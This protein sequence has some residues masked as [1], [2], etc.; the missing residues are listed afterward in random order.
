MRSAI[1]SL[2]AHI[3]APEEASSL[4][5]H[6]QVLLDVINTYG[7]QCM[8]H[9][10]I[11]DTIKSHS[12]EVYHLYHLLWWHRMNLKDCRIFQHKLIKLS[13]ITTITTTTNDVWLDVI[14]NTDM[15]IVLGDPFLQVVWWDRIYRRS[16]QGDLAVLSIV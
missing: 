10:D 9:I 11:V 12:P 13:G 7:I 4:L 5:S 1:R 16:L 2:L 14:D 15:R 3:N 8:Q 6:V